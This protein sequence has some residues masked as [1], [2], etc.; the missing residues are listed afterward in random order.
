[1]AKPNRLDDAFLNIIQDW[2]MMV[3]E[4]AA[5]AVELIM[6]SSGE[7]LTAEQQKAVT[8]FHDLYFGTAGVAE[9]KEAVNREVDDLMDAIQAEMAS[10]VPAA[11]LSGIKED[12]QAKQ[13]RLSLSGVQKKLETIIQLETG[14]KD[15]LVPVLTSMQF[16]D[17]LK[18][19]LERMVGAWKTSLEALPATADEVSTVA[20]KIGKSLGSS[21]EREAF[22]PVVLKRAAPKDVVDDMTMF[23]AFS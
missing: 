20:E 5:S 12:E 19:R 22:Y 11:D 15:K 23:E 10:G 16:E 8:D 17:A 21:V 6:S 3:H 13:A 4:G 7:Y 1:M 18:Q 9:S 14:L 2:T